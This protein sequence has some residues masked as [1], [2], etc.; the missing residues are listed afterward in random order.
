MVYLCDNPVVLSCG[1]HKISANTTDPQ[2]H[3]CIALGACIAKHMRKYYRETNN[4]TKPLEINITR[5]FLDGE[6]AFNITAVC[7]FDDYEKVINIITQISKECYVSNNLR[8]KKVY[9]IIC[10]MYKYSIVV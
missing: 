1:D 9:E 8:Q 5:Q 2:M 4:L 6:D 3:L 7:A 10:G